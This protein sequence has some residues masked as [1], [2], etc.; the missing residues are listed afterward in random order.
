[1]GAS[2]FE[3]FLPCL[4]GGWNTAAST[5]NQALIKAG[6]Y[7]FSRAG[8]Y[9]CQKQRRLRKPP[10]LKLFAALQGDIHPLY[11]PLLSTL[12]FGDPGFF[13]QQ[14]SHGAGLDFPVDLSRVEFDPIHGQQI[15]R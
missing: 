8:F 4:A 1:M 9:T 10:Y 12:N 14:S 13:C 2:G 5:Q 11:S 7:I 6:F 15:N 3:A